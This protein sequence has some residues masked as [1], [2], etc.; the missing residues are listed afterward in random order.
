[1]RIRLLCTEKDRTLVLNT[2]NGRT[3]GITQTFCVP[4]T[5]SNSQAQQHQSPVYLRD[6]DLTMDF[7]W[8]M[9][10]FD[11]WEATQS[12]A[13]FDYRECSSDYGLASYY[14]SKDGNN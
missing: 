12:R 2:V 13:L 3:W 6:V 11:S 10:Y 1:M 7:G 5:N 14:C 4:E 8:C 9:N